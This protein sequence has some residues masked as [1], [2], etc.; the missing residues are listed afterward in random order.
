MLGWTERSDPGD[1]RDQRAT[2]QPRAAP[3]TARGE[4]AVGRAQR[5][6]HRRDQLRDAPHLVRQL[7]RQRLRQ[8]PQHQL[9]LAN[10][11]RELADLLDS[12]ETDGLPEQSQLA[13]QSA[14]LIQAIEAKQDTGL[15]AA[16]RDRLEEAAARAEAAAPVATGVVRQLIDALAGIGI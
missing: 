13:E 15:I 3:Q 2:P 4:R 1:T 11:V 6:I 8:R 9:A 16:A 7:Y 12:H 10:L 5:D 14:K